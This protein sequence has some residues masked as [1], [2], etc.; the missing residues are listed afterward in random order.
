MEH[1]QDLIFVMKSE[2]GVGGLKT[3]FRKA[4]ET[5]PFKKVLL[6]H[7]FVQ[8]GR[9]SAGSFVIPASKIPSE[10]QSQIPLYMEKMIVP[11][12]D[13]EWARLQET[14]KFKRLKHKTYSYIAFRVKRPDIK[15]NESGTKLKPEV[16]EMLN[17]ITMTETARLLSSHFYEVPKILE[18]MELDTIT[19]SGTA[20]MKL[21][22]RSADQCIRDDLKEIGDEVKNISD[23]RNVD[24]TELARLIKKHGNTALS[25][26]APN[27]KR[28]FEDENSSKIAEEVIKNASD[29]YDLVHRLA[30]AA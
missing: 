17:P 15:S 14:Y 5:T 13:G 8:V 29:L 20:N 26:V 11:E 12:V 7:G 16:V 30:T 28:K 6:S 10:F 24:P 2:A 25:E 19:D 22:L 27:A 21:A 18:K 1:E 23:F 4:G 9:A 3:V